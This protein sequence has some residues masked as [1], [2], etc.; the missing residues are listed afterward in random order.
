MKTVL[1]TGGSR[2]IGA[3]MVRAFAHAGYGVSFVY[4]HSRTAAEALAAGTGAQ[5]ICAD[6]GVEEEA[7]AAARLALSHWGHIDVLVNNAG[8]SQSALLTDLTGEEWRRMMAVHLD[9]AFYLSR[10]LLPSMIARHAGK[11]INVSS[12]WGQV[13]ASCEVHYSAAK[14][15]LIGF[16][17]ALSKEVGPSGITVNCIAP[18]VIDTDMNA[19]LTEEDRAALIDETP[20]CR[21]GRV[22]DV[23]AAAAF[24]ASEGAD[25][26]TGQVLAV[27]GGI[28]V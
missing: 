21:I 9:S 28:V 4:L 1:I 17:Q 5:A 14:A 24:L 16:T 15:G 11:I 6:V 26:I 27:N 12:M 2:G 8:I 13:G 25:F 10:A 7:D 19:A 3:E 18:G 20:L 23:A 22:A